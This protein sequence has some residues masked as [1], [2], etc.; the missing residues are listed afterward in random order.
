MALSFRVLGPVEAWLD[1]GPV[2]IAGVKP[3]AI[4]TMLGLNGGSEV[5]A[6]MLTDVLWGED[7]PRTAHKALQ[8]HVSALRNALGDGAVVSTG[9]GWRLGTAGVDATDFMQLVRTARA[10]FSRAAMAEAVESFRGALDLWRGSPALPA[11]VRAQAERTRWA[12][13][14]ESVVD[15]LT[16]AR[17]AAG[18]HGALVGELEAS[19]AASPLRE[20]RWAQLCLALYRS[21]R[22][23][24]ALAAY[25]RARAVLIDELG[26]EPG[27]DLARLERAILAQDSSVDTPRQPAHT[28]VPPPELTISTVNRTARRPQHSARLPT[29]PTTFVGRH[30]ELREISGL[31]ANH[32]IVTITG[33]GGVGKTRL[34]IEAAAASSPERL[35][36]VDL[37]QARPGLVA[38]LIAGALG[39]PEYDDRTLETAIADHIGTEP[40]LMLLD[41]C[42][43]VR[44]AVSALAHHLLEACPGVVVLATSRERLGVSAERVVPAQP[45]TTSREEGAPV[46]DA[47]ALFLDRARSVD[48]SLDADL[49]LVRQVCERCDG[50]PLAIELAAARCASLG[51]DGLLDG[52]DDRL[53]LL[54]GTHSG[55]ARHRSLRTVLDWSHDVLDAQ[56]QE[57]FRRLGIFAGRFTIDAA[58]SVDRDAGL[59]TDPSERRAAIVHLIGRLTDKHLLTYERTPAGSRWRMLDVVR[60]YARERLGHAPDAAAVRERYLRWAARAAER[61]EHQLLNGQ[62]WREEFAYAVDDLRAALLVDAE[63]WPDAADRLALGLALARLHARQGSF[64]L[65]QLAYEQ[66]TSMARKTGDA[67]QLARAA[68]GAS[69]PGML[70]G[71]A[72]DRRVALLEEALT[73]LGSE[74]S[75]TRIR[76]TA[77]LATEL[78]WSS[79]LERS[80]ALAQDAAGAAG[81]LDDHGALAH[82]TYALHYVTRGPGSPDVRLRLAKRIGRSAAMSGETQ[83]ELAGLA[84]LVV[85]LFETGDLVAARADVTALSAAA[86]RLDHPEFQW[87]V[88]VYRLVHALITGQY[89][90]ADRLATTARDA[91][92]V[93]PEFTVGLFFAE[94][95]TDLRDRTDAVRHDHAARFLEMVRRFPRIVL[96]Q[97]LAVRH[98]AE[99]FGQQAVEEVDRLT[100]YLTSREMRDGHWLVACCLVAEAA[101]MVSGTDSARALAAALE[102]YAGDL[103]VAGRVAAFRGSVSHALGLLALTLGDT[104]RAAGYLGASAE[105]HERI[106]ATP[107][108][109]RDLAALARLG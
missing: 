103:A 70:F 9:S 47:E 6:E 37:A 51:V 34:A 98:D 31:L 18:E 15:D 108:H 90:E 97:C 99:M 43:R 8:T 107:F 12:E 96:W 24:D 61:L 85:A 106:G 88:S 95:I 79:E 32:R 66:A 100:Q 78:Y 14:Y 83:L 3:R 40:C 104:E 21:G 89:D 2:A 13:T 58:L 82:A 56:E 10:A 86:D 93:A 94:A 109:A 65:A 75:G 44:H 102:P 20:R 1:G 28:V 63:M 36:Y 23:G 5:S 25:Q 48:P 11:T 77:R 45:L 73:A 105:R 19:L 71:V 91:A 38:E 16:D 26:L 46:S 92:E 17:L 30:S 41:S 4:L 101:A 72:Q 29:P 53:R 55:T 74:A 52:L 39:I 59:D 62:P 64:T 54:V 84:A 69:E 57:M 60:S 27:P 81:R 7:A 33:P 76:L 35:W 67:G 68:L 42:E 49:E 22:Q 50:L 87:Y 80:L